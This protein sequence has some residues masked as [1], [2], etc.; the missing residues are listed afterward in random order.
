[1]TSSKDNT[2]LR[3]VVSP[4]RGTQIQIPKK[5]Y[6]FFEYSNYEVINADNLE[7]VRK[8]RNTPK[9]GAPRMH[10]LELSQVKGLTKPTV[11]FTQQPSGIITYRVL[12]LEPITLTRA[13]DETES[14]MDDLRDQSI[15]VTEAK[16]R[17]SK[18]AARVAAFVPTAKYVVADDAELQE[19]YDS[20]EAS[21][22]YESS[23]T[24]SSCW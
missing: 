7:E 15:G 14:V 11:E 3:L 22:T 1:M 19:A 5:H 13:L 20:Y 17:L 12:Q 4:A 23:Y 2:T 24:S 18:I 9:T 10:K 16:E 21:E 8:I 6:G